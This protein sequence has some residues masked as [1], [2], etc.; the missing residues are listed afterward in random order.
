MLNIEKSGELG[1]E[2]SREVGEYGP[3]IR[4][5]TGSNFFWGDCPSVR[6]FR[7]LDHCCSPWSEHLPREL[8]VVSSIPNRNRPKSLKLVVVT[9]LLGAQDYGNSTTT[10]PPV[11]G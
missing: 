9:F 1:K 7:A 6:Y 4:S 11:S 2:R 8:E 10:G 5:L 3:R